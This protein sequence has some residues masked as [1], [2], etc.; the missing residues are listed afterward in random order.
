[1]TA[2]GFLINRA[3]FRI[4]TF[5]SPCNTYAVRWRRD[6]R[7]TIRSGL[8]PDQLMCLDHDLLVRS[9]KHRIEGHGDETGEHDAAVQE[10]LGPLGHLPEYLGGHHGNQRCRDRE[11]HD[12]YVVSIA[13]EVD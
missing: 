7:H 10:R 2:I 12:Q 6:G 13:F 1:M 8:F 4:L 5:V 11:T 3:S 9:V